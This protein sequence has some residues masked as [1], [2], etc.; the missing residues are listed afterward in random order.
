[1]SPATAVRSEG[2]TG[3]LSAALELKASDVH[4][5]AG[6]PPLARVDGGLLEL[7]GW[8]SLTEEDCK[9]LVYSLLREEQRARLEAELELDCS[10]TI[11]GIGRFRANVFFQRGRVEAALRAVPAVIPTPETLGLGPATMG[12]S[13]LPRGLVLVTGPAGA[14]KTTTLACMVERINASASKHILT[15]EDPIEFLYPRRRALIRQREVGSDTRSFQEAL[16]R[17]LREDPDVI[18]VGEMR[19]AETIALALTAAETG[20]LCLSTLHTVDSAQSIDRI[21]DVFPER[22]QAQVRGQLAAVLKGVLAQMLLPRRGGAG[23]IA[24]R[25]LLLVNSA[26]ANLIREGKTHMLRQTIETSGALG[27]FTLD[28]S[29]A[30]LVQRGAVTMED[31]LARAQDPDRLSAACGR[32]ASRL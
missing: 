23:R 25:E 18:L 26:V 10:L 14:G 31:A 3:I 6:Q 2:A 16:R 1:M 12:L 8:P 20:H 28:R 5:S 11:S 17:A 32:G 9:S 27:M 13:D 29:L 15:I 22:Q 7:S 24:A 21:I 19:D 30:A 4:L